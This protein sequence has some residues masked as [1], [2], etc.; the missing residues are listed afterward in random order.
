[1]LANTVQGQEASG[2]PRASYLRIT[3]ASSRLEKKSL[4]ARARRG[5]ARP[6]R[7]SRGSLSDPPA[8]AAAAA[9]P[10]PGA[11]NT[12]SYCGAAARAGAAGRR[13]GGG[14][15]A[16]APTSLRG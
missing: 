3:A 5:E 11:A 12:T 16:R 8:A 15:L 10:R 7:H 9:A 4:Q 1:M 2:D 13:E 14:R 6:P